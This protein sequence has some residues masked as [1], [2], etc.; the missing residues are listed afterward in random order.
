M[1]QKQKIKQGGL[2]FSMAL[3]FNF[4]GVQTNRSISSEPSMRGKAQSVITWS[5]YLIL[6]LFLFHSMGWGF[7]GLKM[8]IISLSLYIGVCIYRFIQVYIQVCIYIDMSIYILYIIYIYIIFIIFFKALQCI[9]LWSV[10]RSFLPGYSQSFEYS[11]PRCV[12][13]VQ[14]GRK[15]LS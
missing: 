7:F 12:L 13:T 5:V 1:S 9:V 11:W 3:S 15:M 14:N 4:Y 8:C 6:I 10:G 2:L